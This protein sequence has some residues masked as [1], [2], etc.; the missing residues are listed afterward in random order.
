M[1]WGRG[2]EERKG[3]AHSGGVPPTLEQVEADLK[4]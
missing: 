2:G 1:R 3:T 4:K